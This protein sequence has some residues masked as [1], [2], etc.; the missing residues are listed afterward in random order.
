MYLTAPGTQHHRL[1]T[2]TS[3]EKVNDIYALL[4]K[5]EDYRDTQ[6]HRLFTF[7]SKEKGNDIFA[8]LVNQDIM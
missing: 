2:F 7:T 6:H 1:F 5:Q 3:K 8:L 4:V